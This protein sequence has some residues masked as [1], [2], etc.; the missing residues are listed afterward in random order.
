MISA[1]QARQIV[2]VA[3]QVTRAEAVARFRRIDMQD[4]E[5]KSNPD[6][7]VTEADRAVENRLLPAIRDI[8]PDATLIGEESVAADPGLLGRLRD[9]RVVILD[10]IDGTWNYAHGIANWGTII[11]VAEAGRV[12]W[13][14]LLDPINDDWIEAHAGGGA[15]FCRGDSRVRLDLTGRPTRMADAAAVLHFNLYPAHVKPTIAGFLPSMR[16]VIYPGSSCHEYRLLA[17]GK[18]DV[19]LNAMLNPWDHAAGAMILAEAGGVTR[20][21]NGGIHDPMMLTGRMLA[22]TNE[23]LW[24]EAA[25]LMAPAIRAAGD[26]LI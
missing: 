13:G 10:P 6:D 19:S 22:A 9:D 3:R 26:P 18:I 4:V 5:A 23:T 24:Q 7:L 12:V 21:L 1:D 16:R 2:D 15:W 14:C 8:L 17:A 20:L 11:A 25:G